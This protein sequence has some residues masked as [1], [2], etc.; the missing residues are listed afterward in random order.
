MATYVVNPEINQVVRA[1]KKGQVGGYQKWKTKETEVPFRTELGAENLV[2]QHTGQVREAPTNLG[3]QTSSIGKGPSTKSATGSKTR[4][5]VNS[6]MIKE[7]NGD[8]SVSDSVE[9]IGAY[10][11]EASKEN[12]TEEKDSEGNKVVSFKIKSGR[13]S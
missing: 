7:I 8:L 1:I 5:Y 4:I 9:L 6:N 11:R 12:A 3:P 13:K 10:F 2:D